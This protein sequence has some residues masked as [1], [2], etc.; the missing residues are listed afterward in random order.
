MG[1]R[2]RASAIATPENVTPPPYYPDHPIVRQE[3]A[4]YL[5]SVSGHGPAH[6]LGAGPAAGR[7]TGRRHDRDLLRR[8]RPPG[9]ARHPLVLRQRPARAADHPLAEEFS[10]A[11]ADTRLARSMDRSSACST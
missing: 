1:R 6:R 3:W 7:R 2:A 5:N 8:Q 11:A 4:R 9:A 10:R